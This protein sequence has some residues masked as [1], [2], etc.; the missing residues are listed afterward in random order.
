MGRISAAI[1][2]SAARFVT[3]LPDDIVPA[4]QVVL[5]TRGRPY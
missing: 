1:V 5:M 2:D 4:P 3:A